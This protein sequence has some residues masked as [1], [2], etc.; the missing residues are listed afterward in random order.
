MKIPGVY[1]DIKGDITQLKADMAQARRVVKDSAAGMSNDMNNALSPQQVTR[2]INALVSD[3]T[4][5]QRAA[6]VTGK[7]FDGL[8]V[9]L[10]ELQSITGLT[11]KEFAKLQSRM[12]ENKATQQAER[13]LKSIARATGLSNKEMLSLGRQMGLSRKS[14][15][16]MAE[17]SDKARTSFTGFGHSVTMVTGAVTALAGGLGLIYLSSSFLEAARESEGFRVRLN[18]TLGSVEE[19]GRLFQEMSDYAASVP[20]Q[21]NE[22]MSA[23]TSLSGVMKGGVDEIKQWMPM[24]GDLA[25][26]SGL[27]IE[28]TTSQIVRM[29]SAGAGAAD[30]FR[31]RGVLAMMGFEAGV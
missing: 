9:E 16:S 29:Y 31:E 27:T 2:G 11:G 8:G 3:L 24:I 4:K 18:A 1:V 19:G 15:K 14:I 7:D 20:F 28:E 6:S 12:L 17:S 25:A 23:A 21:Y 5:L 26:V 22:I 10:K 30:L 13:S